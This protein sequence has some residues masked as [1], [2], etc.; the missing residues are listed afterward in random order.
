MEHMI[1]F[2]QTVGVIQSM[3]GILKQLVGALHAVLPV[4][5]QVAVVP[6]DQVAV[7]PVDQVAVVLA[8]GQ[9]A[10]QAAHQGVLRGP[11]YH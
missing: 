1:L 9:P 5:D 4:G 7:V 8:D 3:E 10:E 11:S 6:G 2:K